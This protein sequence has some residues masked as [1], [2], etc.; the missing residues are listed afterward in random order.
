MRNRMLRDVKYFK[1]RIGGLDGANDTG[2][3]IIKVVQDKNVPRT[4]ISPSPPTTTT[5]TP[6]PDTQTT[7]PTAGNQAALENGNGGNS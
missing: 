2:D 4:S 1:T 3:Y 7:P 5:T 6:P